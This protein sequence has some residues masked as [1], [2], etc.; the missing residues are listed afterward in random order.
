MNF[1]LNPLDAVHEHGV[2]AEEV[3][4]V[5]SK[6]LHEE[7]GSGRVKV[8]LDLTEDDLLKKECLFHRVRCSVI[9]QLNQ[10]PHLE[11]KTLLLQEKQQQITNP[12]RSGIRPLFLK[13][14]YISIKM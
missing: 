8:E 2:V 9:A 13:M 14:R 4:L 3:H 10:V 5:S 11:R 7:E 1:S 6:R 12:D